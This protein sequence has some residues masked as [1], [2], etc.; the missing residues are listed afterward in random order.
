LK[1]TILTNSC[2]SIP[3]KL[4]ETE[5]LDL[6]YFAQALQG[7]DVTC[8]VLPFHRFINRAPLG[9]AYD[10]VFLAASSQYTEYKAYIDDVLLCIERGGGRL[11]PSLEIFRCHDNKFYQEIVKQKLGIRSPRSWLV[12][13]V[14]ECESVLGDAPFPL[15]AK[16][17]SGFASSGV[18]LVRSLGEACSYVK[19]VGEPIIPRRK[20]LLARKK[21]VDLYRGKLPLCVGRVVFQEFID[22]AAHDWKVLVFG[23]RY[24][25]IKRFTRPDDF[26]ASG[27]GLM[28]IAAPCPPQVLDFAQECYRKLNMPWASL[29]IIE[30]GGEP[31]LIEF[32]GVHFGLYALMKSESHYTKGES[33]W[34]M[35]KNG[36]EP[37]EFYFCDAL[38]THLK[39]T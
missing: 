31:S 14:E 5:G 7:L 10:Q 18:A 37:T 19:G 33:G 25:T 21:Q 29:D 6:E 15:V 27:S 30:S 28:D 22:Q 26:R 1:I 16:K 23:S 11:V 8:E 36:P 32:Q 20:N 38:L 2:G 13:S 3:Q 4:H 12:G 17:S 39:E 24:F 34:Q 35:V 9:T